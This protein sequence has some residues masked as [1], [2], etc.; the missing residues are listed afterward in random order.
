MG[1]LPNE[2]SV[3][4]WIAGLREGEDEAAR[5]LW[6]RYFQRIVDLARRKLGDAPR[7]MADEEDI[8]LDALD[9]LCRGAANGRFGELTDRSDLWRLLIAITT[10]KTLEQK[11]FNVRQK[12][13]GGLVRGDSVFVKHDHAASAGFEQMSAPD[14]DPEFLALV[15]EQHERLMN[16]LR[17]DTLRRV[18]RCRMEGYSNKEIAEELGSTVRTV[19]RKL[20]LIRDSWERELD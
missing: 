1:D 17:D 8:A 12:R 10:R 5:Q 11:R 18:A 9:S 2:Q 7:R 4:A 20:N 6:Q 13:G 14:P 16:S 19:E 15:Q 3:T